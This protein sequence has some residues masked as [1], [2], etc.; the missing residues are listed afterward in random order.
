MVD[1]L[2]EYALAL[3]WGGMTAL[4]TAVML[5]IALTV[6]NIPL[7]DVPMKRHVCTRVGQ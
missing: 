7:E 1:V 3:F 2:K 4:A 5:Y 6:G